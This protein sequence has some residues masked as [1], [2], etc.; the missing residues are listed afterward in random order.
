MSNPTNEPKWEPCARMGIYDGR[1][2]SHAENVSLILNPRTG[3][4][5]P[6]FIVVYN[7]DFTTV[8]YL[9][10]ATVPPHWV[11]IVKASSTI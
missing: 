11:E 1:S 8:P 3:H 10:N 4:V 5:S 6:Q 9:R 2:P 7:N